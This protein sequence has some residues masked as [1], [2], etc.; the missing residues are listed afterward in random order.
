[1]S[2]VE[3]EYDPVRFYTE[4]RAGILSYPR[5]V[6]TWQAWHPGYVDYYVYR[7][8]ERANRARAQQFVVGRTQDVAAL[9]SPRLR[10]WI[11]ENRIE[12]ASFRDVLTGRNDYQRRLKAAGSDLAMI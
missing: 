3:R 6:V 10:A 9:T 7:L 12:L 5:D 4:D 11:R 8:G 1:M 2:A